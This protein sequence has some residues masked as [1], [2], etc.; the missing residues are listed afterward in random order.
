MM[1]D[2]IVVGIQTKKKKKITSLNFSGRSIAQR[3]FNNP[4]VV[5]NPLCD[6]LI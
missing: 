5:G 1:D 4:R 3:V 6:G 2:K